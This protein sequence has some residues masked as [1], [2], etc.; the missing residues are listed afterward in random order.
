[1]PPS[2][3]AIQYP[4][5][6]D[7]AAM[8]VGGACRAWPAG[9]PNAGAAPKA[10]TLPGPSSAAVAVIPPAVA[11]ATFAALAVFA[12]FT[13]ATEPEPE[14]DRESE[15]APVAAVRSGDAAVRSGRDVA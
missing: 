11:L 8:A 1:M 4:R 14:P 2:L 12:A 3:A 7:V 6:V 9:D 13:P 5:P 10:K 15:P